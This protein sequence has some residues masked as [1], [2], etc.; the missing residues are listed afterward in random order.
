[1]S[2]FATLVLAENLMCARLGI[3]FAGQAARW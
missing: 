3:A 1:M 2:A